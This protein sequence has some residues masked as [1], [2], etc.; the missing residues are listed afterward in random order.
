MKKLRHVGDLAPLIPVIWY[1]LFMVSLRLSELTE[2]RPPRPRMLVWYITYWA[3]GKTFGMTMR[4]GK[5][6][7]VA[8]YKS[9]SAL[10]V[11]TIFY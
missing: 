2:Q 7:C 1:V 3:E 5:D 9:A 10:D 8:W 6:S 4:T 11:R